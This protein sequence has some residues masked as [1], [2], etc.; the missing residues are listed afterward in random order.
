MPEART[1]AWIHE[2]PTTDPRDTAAMKLANPA[3]WI[4]EDDLARQAANPEL[5]DAAVLQLHG[6]V[7]AERDDTWLPRGVWDQRY[8][9][10][11][12][13]PGEQVVLA[14]DGSYRRDATAPIGC[15]LDGHLFVV[16]V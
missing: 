14:F 8:E 3:P 6:C 11:Q 1:L 9:R 7:W 15:T 16:A 5:S 13:E 2:A 12:A 4:G 10:R